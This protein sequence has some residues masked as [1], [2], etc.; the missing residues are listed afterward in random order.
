MT[1]ELLVCG[2]TDCNEQATW[3]ASKGQPGQ[4]LFLCP[5]HVAF[6]QAGKHQIIEIIEAGA[7]GFYLQSPRRK[8]T[9]AEIDTSRK[10]G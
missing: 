10:R 6:V 7:H 4:A 9:P 1:L 5:M 3:Q 8:L 2:L